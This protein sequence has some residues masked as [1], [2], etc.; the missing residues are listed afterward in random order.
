MRN[1]TLA[2][3]ADFLETAIIATSTDHGFAIVHVGVCEFGEPFV[4]VNDSNGKNIVT[5]P[6]LYNN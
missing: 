1:L 5:Q 2:E 6:T 3:T 4:L